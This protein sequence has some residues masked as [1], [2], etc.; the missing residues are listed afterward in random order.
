MTH[1]YSRE[2]TTE[3][4]QF[5]IMQ[6][7]PPGSKSKESL[8]CR[9]PRG[10]MAAHLVTALNQNP[11][12]VSKIQFKIGDTVQF[13]TGSRNK[14][15]LATGPDG[16]FALVALP[17]FRVYKSYRTIAEWAEVCGDS[18]AKI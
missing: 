6:V 10:D 3:K 12:P 1:Y 14:Y 8:V 13:Q 16:E 2:S 9:T 15:I 5:T 18:V 11:L 4:G 7:N 17:E